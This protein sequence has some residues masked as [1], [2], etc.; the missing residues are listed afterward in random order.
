MTG[1]TS[2]LGRA[3]AGALA[4]LGARVI[5]V[6]RSRERLSA[7][8]A[9]LAPRHGDAERFPVVVADM[10]SLADVREAVAAI[11]ATEPRLDILVDSAGAIHAT[12]TVT[13]DGLEATFAT[14]VV[15]PFVLIS[16]LLP[17]LERSGDGR[18]ITVVSGGMY[19]QALPLDDLGVRSGRVQ[20]NARL[21]PG[22]AGGHRPDP[23]VGAAPAR[24]PR[25]GQRHAPRLGGHA[26][27]CRIAARVPRPHGS[28]PEDASRGHRHG[29][30][31]GDRRASR[32]T[33][34]STLPRP[35]ATSLRPAALHA[36]LVSAATLALG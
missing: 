31:A 23:R 25:A 2:G 4:S 19:G 6:G 35:A 11:E 34:R 7:T 18:V 17:M 9:E 26:R 20:R 5:L 33:W 8:A 12:R 36:P 22:E 3:T 10:S 16:G 29:H 21:R 15:G 27:P 14:M 30:L 13:E 1:P 24:A 32:P 28:A